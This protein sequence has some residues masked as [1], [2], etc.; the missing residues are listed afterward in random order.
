MLAVESLDTAV[1]PESERFGFW[2]DLVA[3]ESVPMRVQSDHAGNFRA[4]ARVVA[5]GDI[6]LSS[7][8]YPSLHMQRTAKQIRSSDPEM[9][10]LALPLSGTG[11]LTQGRQENPLIAGSFA[12]VDTSRP[13]MSTHRADAQTNDQVTT[14]TLLVPHALIPLHPD[15]VDKLLG[16]NIPATEGFGALLGQFV[17]RI[18]DHPD[19]YAAGD[20]ARLDNVARELVAAALGQRLD[21]ADTLAEEVRDGSLRTQITAFIDRNLDH[22]D[23]DPTAVAA[24]HHISVR[25]LHRLFEK[26]DRSIAGLIRA[27]RLDRCARDLRDPSLRNRPIYTIAA[28]WGFADK[29]HFSRLFRVTFGVSPQLYRDAGGLIAAAQRSTPPSAAG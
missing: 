19:E 4:Q 18:L 25:T 8:Q 16:T 24:A 10:H 22:P 13:H 3:R 11:G 26:E 14:L 2:H 9:Y 29:A 15:K 28:R 5:L 20:A 21:V 1:L 6:V 17:K 7:W 23:L 27:K 12:L